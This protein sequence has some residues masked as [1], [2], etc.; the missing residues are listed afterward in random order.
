L[1]ADREYRSYAGWRLEKSRVIAFSATKASLSMLI[2]G[3]IPSPKW[4]FVAD[5]RSAITHVQAADVSGF[6]VYGI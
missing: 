5:V 1:C 4:E 3:D 2:L 6:F